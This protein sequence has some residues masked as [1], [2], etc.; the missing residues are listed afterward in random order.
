MVSLQCQ[1][2]HMTKVGTHIGGRLTDDDI[3]AIVLAMSEVEKVKVDDLEGRRGD[4]EYFHKLP[5]I[6]P[7]KEFAVCVEADDKDHRHVSLYEESMKV[8]VVREIPEV[9]VISN[10][11]VYF[12]S[13]KFHLE[14]IYQNTTNYCKHDYDVT[15]CLKL[16]FDPP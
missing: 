13:G 8:Y 12:E 9:A 2:F 10:E 6:Y 11:A 7:D 3:D 1:R 14:D 15:E 4:P 16:L 5:D